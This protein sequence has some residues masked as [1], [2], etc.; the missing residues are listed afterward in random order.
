MYRIMAVASLILLALSAPSSTKAERP[1]FADFTGRFTREMLAL[2]PVSATAVGYHHHTDARTGVT[3]GLDELLDDY[4][5]AGLRDR[6]AVMGGLRQQL[7]RFSLTSLD[8]QE[9]IDLLLMRNALAGSAFELDRIQAYRHNPTLY[10]STLGFA[11][12]QP[13]V[14]EYAPLAARLGHIFARLEKI[15]AFLAQARRNLVDTD[16]VYTRA[17]AE[18]TDGNISL[19][20]HQLKQLVEQ[21]GSTELRTR[22]E[23]IV[24]QTIVALRD[25]NHFLNE[26]LARRSTGT[27]RLGSSRYRQKLRYALGTDLTPDELL[28]RAERRLADLRAEML[29]TAA[30]LHDEFFPSHG[31]HNELEAHERQ[32]RIIR[33]VLDKIAEE[34]PQRDALL[35]Q[36]RR[37]LGTIRQFI[38][39]KAIVSLPRRDNLQVIETPPFI[40]S[41]YGVAGFSSA[42]P[43]EPYL[44][45]FFWVTPIPPDWSAERAEQKLREYNRYTLQILT[46]HEA[47]PGHYLQFEHA[48]NLQPESRRVLRAVFSNGPYVEGWAMYAETVMLANGYLNGSPRLKLMHQ[49]WQ[50][51]SVANAVLDVRLHTKN[52]T[53]EQA[54]DLMMRDTFQE[55]PEAE[56]KLIRAKLSSAQ[57]PTYFVGLLG[58]QEIREA[59]ERAQGPKFSQKE[60]HDRAL[61]VGPMPLPELRRLLMAS[62]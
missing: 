26:D 46:I 17:A 43:L 61:A 2:Q 12:F 3:L 58:W 60:F 53:D 22:Y 37:D 9:R 5:A 48:G 8:P 11:I 62:R 18:G 16:P 1:R 30:P 34:H 35:E 47:L 44:G 40:R 20:E 24:P 10:S 29:A 57:L 23:R 41:W 27:W 50:L 39:D 45:A 52:M 49:K 55:R 31:S 21:S 25:F 33:E 7:G 32:N 6:R 56:A 51:R 59:V 54:L 15:P 28:I 14:E 38:R 4:S 36:V 13:M 42:P 19:L